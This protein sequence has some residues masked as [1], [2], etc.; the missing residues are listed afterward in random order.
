MLIKAL[1]TLF[2]GAYKIAS[3]KSAWSPRGAS[4]PVM[5]SKRLRLQTQW[6]APH[7]VCRLRL[8]GPSGRLRSGRT[9]QKLPDHHRR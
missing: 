4:C 5:L 6:R 3:Q 1:L 9:A 8:H 7:T 2:S